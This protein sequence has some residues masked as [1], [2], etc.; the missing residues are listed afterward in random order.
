MKLLSFAGALAVTVAAATPIAAQ[1]SDTLP[2]DSAVRAWVTQRVDNGY[3]PS[4]VIGLLDHGKER[5]ISAGHSNFGNTPLV[6]PDAIYEIGSITKVFTN[7]ILADMVVKGEVSL[8]DPVSKYLPS[9]VTMPSRNGKVITLLDLA[10]AS[11]G[12]PRMPGNF[13]PKDID[14]PFADY[15][16]QQMYDFL[17]SY[18]LPREPGA[19]YEYSNLGM[20]LLGHA[21][22]LKAGKSYEQLLIDRVLN[23]LGMKDT[24]ITLTPS[25]AKRFVVGHNADLEA[26]PAWDLPTLAGAGALRSSARDMMKFARAVTAATKGEGPLAKAIALSIE[27]RRPTTIPN[28]RIGL[29]WHIRD[30]NDTHI[31]WHN[32]GTGGFRTWFGFDPATSNAAVVLTNGGEVS[33]E[34]GFHLLDP[35]FPMRPIMPQAVVTVP[36]ETLDKY[37]G[38]YALTPA[39]VIQIAHEGEKLFA[40]ATNQPRFRLWATNDHEFYLKTVPAKVIFGTDSTGTVTLTLDQNGMKQTARKQ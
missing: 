26:V 15:T 6:D 2:S 31:V 34:L 16:V 33:D 25:M 4:I 22:A 23:P 20:G 3:A 11:S 12:L 8:D 14:N 24:R 21:L 5:Y 35:K 27:P 10:T 1:R 40:K 29:A 37:V 7:L 30:V 32:G 39:F 36:N 17:S 18:S 19:Q 9:S 13:H 38:T 28:M